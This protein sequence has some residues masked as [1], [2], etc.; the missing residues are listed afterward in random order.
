MIHL[1]VVTVKRPWQTMI[2]QEARK[3][4]FCKSNGEV[5]NEVRVVDWVQIRVPLSLGPPKS[6]TKPKKKI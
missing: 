6:K 5:G 2:V 4:G 1:V 3:G